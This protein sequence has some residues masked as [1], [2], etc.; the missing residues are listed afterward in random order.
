MF[1]RR[2]ARLPVDGSGCV[3][4]GQSSTPIYDMTLVFPLPIHVLAPVIAKL[5]GEPWSGQ[6]LWQRAF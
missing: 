2:S 6:A 4:S 5:R 1:G 3:G